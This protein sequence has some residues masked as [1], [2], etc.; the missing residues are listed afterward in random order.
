MITILN[1]SVLTNYGAYVY[2]PLTLNE[3]KSLISG[4]FESA[5][6]H[7]STCDILSVLLGKEIKLNRVQYSQKAGDVALIFKLKSRSEEGKIL[8][9]E[10]IEKI[11]YEFGRLTRVS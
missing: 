4:G 2:E 10:E 9:A 3:S 8:T 6:G 1:T 7:Q 5:V 11:G